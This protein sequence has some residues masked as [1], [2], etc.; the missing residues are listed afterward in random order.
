MTYHFPQGGVKVTQGI[1]SGVQ[2]RDWGWARLMQAVLEGFK[3]EEAER[4]ERDERMRL[5]S[6]PPEPKQEDDDPALWDYMVVKDRHLAQA[7]DDWNAMMNKQLLAE[8]K[9]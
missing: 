5:L 9:L 8:H 6:I 4:A 2:P 1:R 3:R 7:L